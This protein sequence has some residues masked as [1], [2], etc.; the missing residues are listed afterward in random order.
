MATAFAI[1]V[2]PVPG[3]PYNKIPF[4]GFIP[5]YYWNKF[6]NCLNWLTPKKY[7]FFIMKV[8]QNDKRFQ[9]TLME[10]Q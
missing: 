1:K 8:Y 2:F 7:F 6:K 3:G 4:A 5:K 10:V 9:V